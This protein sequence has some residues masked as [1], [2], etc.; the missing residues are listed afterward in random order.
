[1]PF[2][3]WMT[4][5]LYDPHQGYYCTPGLTRWGRK[6]DY[7]TS[8]ERSSLFAAT[9]AR[10]FV[11]LHRKFETTTELVLFEVGAGGGDFAYGV[12]DHMQRQYQDIY[13]NTWYIVHE[14]SE[15]LRRMLREKLKP[16]ETQVLYKSMDA[17]DP[18]DPGIIFANELLDAFPVHR[19]VKHNGEVREF[20]V[21]LDADGNFVW[22]LESISSERLKEHLRR[23]ELQLVEGQIA[24]INLGIEDWLKV[25]ANKLAKGYLILV[26]YGAEAKQLYDF[27]ARPKGT[28]RS[29]H[30]HQ[31]AENLLASPGTRDLTTTIDWTLVR[32]ISQDLG[33]KVV[34]F[35]VQDQFLMSAG[36]LDELKSLT[37]EMET[38]AER[39]KMR[40]QSREMILP[41]GMAESFQVLVLSKG[42]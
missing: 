10:Y 40:T 11:E 29:V 2:H 8:P 16:F 12:L 17:L 9:F 30:R 36:I 26:D 38:E 20:Y 35:D 6:G 21:N 25:A 27:R 41:S 4:A 37:N 24:E 19:V 1:M 28:L 13:Q 39:I 32:N 22:E 3:Q 5:A 14:Q 7:R 15:D 18:L 33:F 23:P 31:F 42:L 34:Q